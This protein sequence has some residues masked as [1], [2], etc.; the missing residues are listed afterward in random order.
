VLFAAGASVLLCVN[1]ASAKELK[2]VGVSI[3]NLNYPF[4]A[5]I[6]KGAEFEARN[7]KITTV[8]HNFD[9][10]TQNAQI[11]AL[12]AAGVDLIVLNPSDTN[13]IEPAID[14][15][16]KAGIPVVAA[17]SRTAGAD[18]T[19]ETNNVQAGAVA[20]EYVVEKMGGK[21]AMLI[22]SFV[23]TRTSASD[24][25]KGC[26]DVVAKHPGVKILPQEEDTLGSR[27]GG[28]SVGVALLARFPQ[29][30]GVFALNDYSA[31]GM[32]AAAKKL[33]RVNFPITGVDGT[34]E[35]VQALKDPRMGCERSHD[36]SIGVAVRAVGVRESEYASAGT[37]H[38]FDE[39]FRANKAGHGEA[40]AVAFLD[41]AHFAG[42][43]R[44]GA[45]SCRL[46]GGVDHVLKL[47]EGAARQLPDL[48]VTQLVV[49]GEELFWPF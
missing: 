48:H 25:A 49:A 31:L 3:A 6:A 34:P 45:V 21:G 23:A 47:A 33:N 24:R 2:S 27:D 37:A 43:N 28:F 46:R 18:V 11:D 41:C 12:I 4:F 42:R 38:G 30:D 5:S 44:I 15:A 9:P 7:V 13:A 16:H 8:E 17:D 39:A 32:A 19:V 35:A 29:I 10:P 14:R 22:L 1:P 36:S 20:C 26:S 40:V